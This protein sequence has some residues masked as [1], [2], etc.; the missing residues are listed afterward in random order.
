MPKKMSQFREGSL[1]LEI[2]GRPVQVSDIGIKSGL[3]DN[4]THCSECRIPLCL[5]RLSQ[6]QSQ[7]LGL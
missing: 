6:E 4:F 3:G 1:H 7:H 5:G 2:R